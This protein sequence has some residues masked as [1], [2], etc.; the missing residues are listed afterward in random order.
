[1]T[2]M[3]ETKKSWWQK[4]REEEMLKRGA[5]ARAKKKLLKVYSA[6]ELAFF[7]ENGYE[8]VSHQPSAFAAQHW[9]LK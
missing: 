5:K 9:L 4:A 1:M 2:S 7:L 8:I 3:A 6:K